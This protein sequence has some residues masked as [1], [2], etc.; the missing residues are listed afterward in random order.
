MTLLE[1]AVVN[2]GPN[3]STTHEQ[4]GIALS[5]DKHNFGYSDSLVRVQ[6]EFISRGD[7]VGD[8]KG[9]WHGVVTG[10]VALAGCPYPAG[11]VIVP[12]TIG[13]IQHDYKL[14]IQLS[15]GNWWV[16]FNDNWLGYYPGWR[17]DL[18]NASAAQAFWYGEVYDPTP[19]NWTWMDMGSGL[20]ASTGANNASYFRNPYY[21]TPSGSATWADGAANVGPS[22]SACYT[23]SALYTGSPPFDRYF[24]LGGPGG[25][26]SGCD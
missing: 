2:S 12:S 10:F 15:G 20:F 14:G 8:D 21:I 4:V 5:R 13:G 1:M 16:S 25:E 23:K 18:I 22:A 17:F 24:Y 6:V 19:T 3:P 7:D 11:T 26:A 9:G